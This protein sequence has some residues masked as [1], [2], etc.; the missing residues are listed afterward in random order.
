MI[1]IIMQTHVKALNYY[2]ACQVYTAEFVSKAHSILL[3]LFNLTYGVVCLQLAQFS[4]DDRVNVYFISLTSSIQ[5][6]VWNI[7]HCLGFVLETMV[8]AVCVTML[9]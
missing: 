7:N 2:N 3:S 4:F 6:E 1:I 5:S 8:C 9:F